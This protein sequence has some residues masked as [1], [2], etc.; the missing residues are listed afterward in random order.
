MPHDAHG[1]TVIVPRQTVYNDIAH[2]AKQ[3]RTG[4]IRWLAREG[5]ECFYRESR[6]NRYAR[7]G[8]HY[9]IAQLTLAWTH[10]SKAKAYDPYESARLFVRTYKQGGTKA[11][12]KHWR[13]FH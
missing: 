13:T 1:R 8:S 10:G 12:R 9:G 6:F 11:V 3:Y 5:T 4:S 7:T 2:W